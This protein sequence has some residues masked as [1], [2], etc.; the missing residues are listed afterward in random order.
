[1]KSSRDNP[2]TAQHKKNKQETRTNRAGGGA[3]RGGQPRRVA[4]HPWRTVGHDTRHAVPSRLANDL[5]RAL[6]CGAVGLGVV[7]LQQQ[8]QER[9]N[10]QRSQGRGQRS[11]GGRSSVTPSLTYDGDVRGDAA[12]LRAVPVR[13]TT[14]HL[15]TGAKAH[16]EQRWQYTQ[17][18]QCRLPHTRCDTMHQHHYQAHLGGRRAVPWA[19]EAT[20]AGPRALGVHLQGPR[21]VAAG[22]ALVPGNTRGPQ[23]NRRHSVL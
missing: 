12:A 3:R 22:G 16:G 10:D 14:G 4:V 6:V 13:A 19:V 1:M 18:H 11:L 7:A 15:P 9:E 21:A 5:L 8:P 20:L 2:R 17:I 23:G